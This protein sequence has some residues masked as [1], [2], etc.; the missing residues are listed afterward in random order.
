[1]KKAPRGTCSECR[2]EVAL[3]DR[4][5]GLVVR[6]HSARL[7]M[8]A[9]CAGSNRAPLPAPVPAKVVG[10]V[11]V[12][13]ALVL[14]CAS[15]P[16]TAHQRDFVILTM[17]RTIR[18]ASLPTLRLVLEVM[19]DCIRTTPAEWVGF[20]HGEPIRVRYAGEEQVPESVG[21]GR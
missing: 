9:I 4:G 11:V 16:H 19:H 8:G 5:R 10:L 1:M 20:G 18:V 6:Q 13:A 21:C 3:I 12:L 2:R 17:P 14:G 15:A 7:A